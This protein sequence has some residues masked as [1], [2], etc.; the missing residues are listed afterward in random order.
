MTVLM[1]EQ[2][3]AFCVDAIKLIKDSNATYIKKDTTVINDKCIEIFKNNDD[4]IVIKFKEKDY[5]KASDPD[6]DPEPVYEELP[7]KG[8][9]LERIHNLERALD[10]AKGLLQKW[11]NPNNDREK[12]SYFTEEFLKSDIMKKRQGAIM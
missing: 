8:S 5:V 11:A 6:P 10:I 7:Y 12:L 9:P 1:N 4:E 2:D 3:I